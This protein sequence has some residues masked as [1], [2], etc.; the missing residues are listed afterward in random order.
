MKNG[1]RVLGLNYPFLIR[2]YRVR[3]KD[4]ELWGLKSTKTFI[5]SGGTLRRRIKFN[6][7][8]S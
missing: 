1:I 4:I 2:T 6:L 5:P 8:S 3:L 7:W